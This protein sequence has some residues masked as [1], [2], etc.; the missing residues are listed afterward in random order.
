VYKKS[1]TWLTDK[2]GSGPLLPEGS[3]AFFSRRLSEIAGLG[4]V[5]C[6]VLYLGALASYA[7]TDP[8]LNAAGGAQVLNWLGRP[9]A[10]VADLMLQTF[11]LIALLPAF[12]SMAWGQ[13]LF[14]KLGVGQLWLRSVLALSALLLLATSAA[15]F[16]PF[17]GWPLAASLGGVAGQVLLERVASVLALLHIATPDIT[18]MMVA[19]IL[20]VPGFAALLWALALPH[21]DW[22]ALGR[23]LAF[24]NHQVGHG[25]LNVVGRLRNRAPQDDFLDDDDEEQDPVDDGVLR[26]PRRRV[27]PSPKSKRKAWSKPKPKPSKRV[28]APKP[29]VNARWIW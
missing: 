6:G 1:M 29:N 16:K 23:G 26:A 27:Q 13:L 9:G 15:V 19:A 11:G 8:S 3:S 21:S 12:L 22:L 24:V 4:I 18:I 10:I 14:R 7:P 17:D 25:L 20:A 2:L 5:T 28:A